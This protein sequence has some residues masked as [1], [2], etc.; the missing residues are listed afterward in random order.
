M[1]KKKHCYKCRKPK[2]L[3]DFHLDGR[4]LDG[5][6]SKCKVCVAKYNTKYRK[7]NRARLVKQCRTWR[8]KNRNYA[9]SHHKAYRDRTRA[10]C[11]VHYGGKRPRC[12][13]CGEEEYGFL[14]IDHVNGNGRRHRDETGAHGNAFYIWLRAHGFPRGYR[15]LCFNCNSG[16]ALN[17][18]VCPHKR[19]VDRPDLRK[20]ARKLRNDRA[21]HLTLRHR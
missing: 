8:K 20:P 4:R 15:V 19:A 11:I 3:D 7:K 2:K 16:R 10:E 1:V 18:N 21:T 6:G 12:A 5:H 14:T 9:L 13:C 17:G